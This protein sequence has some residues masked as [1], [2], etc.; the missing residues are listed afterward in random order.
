MMCVVIT[1]KVTDRILGILQ[2]LLWEAQE[3]VFVG[4]L[5]R[6]MLNALWQAVTNELSKEGWI[7]FISEDSKSETGFMIRNAGPTAR[8]IRDQDGLPS[9]GLRPRP[10]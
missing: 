3:G 7:V 9:L 8:E 1:S 6:K 5:N 2:T 10:L 4:Q